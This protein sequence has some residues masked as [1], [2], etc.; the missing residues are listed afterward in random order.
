MLDYAWQ[1]RTDR[2]DGA[3][4][5]CVLRLFMRE[6]VLHELHTP[7]SKCG[8]QGEQDEIAQPARLGF[9]L[10]VVVHNE[11]V[12]VCRCFACASSQQEQEGKRDDESEADV[13]E[14]VS[15]TE[16]AG[17][18]LNDSFHR[19]ERLLLSFHRIA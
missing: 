16:H 4:D 1:T 2:V 15:E 10:S 13:A 6:H 5:V 19:H 18:C 14:D 11:S 3:R 17:L 7:R 9:G 8:E 12:C